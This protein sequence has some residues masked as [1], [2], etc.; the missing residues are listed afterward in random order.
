[1]GDAVKALRKRISD[2]EGRATDF[3][4][5]VT[6]AFERHRDYINDLF[7]EVETLKA[8]NQKL[9]EKLKQQ[10]AAIIEILDVVSALKSS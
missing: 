3:E 2:H 1:M 6:G 10:D 9:H 5:A 8:E 4:K 7:T